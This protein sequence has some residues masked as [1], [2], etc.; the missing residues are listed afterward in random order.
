[1]GKAILGLPNV[2]DDEN[3]RAGQQGSRLPVMMARRDC[4]PVNGGYMAEH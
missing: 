2:D 4:P 1:M 3:A